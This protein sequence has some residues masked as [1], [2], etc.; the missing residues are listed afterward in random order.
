MFPSGT[1]GESSAFS[2]I[3]FSKAEE[4]LPPAEHSRNKQHPII[5]NICFL[6]ANLKKKQPWKLSNKN[7]VYQQ[8][9]E[10]VW[11]VPQFFHGW[12]PLKLLPVVQLFAV[13][14]FL[15]VL[16]SLLTIQRHAMQSVAFYDINDDHCLLFYLALY[17]PD[18][19]KKCIIETHG[20]AIVSLMVMLNTVHFL[21]AV[22]GIWWYKNRVL[23]FVKFLPLSRRKL[24]TNIC[25]H[26]RAICWT[27]VLS[28]Y[29]NTTREEVEI[30]IY[31]SKCMCRKSVWFG[32]CLVQGGSSLLPDY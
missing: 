17:V 19:S 11:Q 29:W 32:H 2:D 31:C 1:V 6:W 14:F 3:L 25:K 27:V 5:W 10:A 24:R 13:C 9:I 30:S 12:C 23:G 7:A 15:P 16:L 8:N 18:T 21:F 22:R 26:S 20:P 4:L 28:L